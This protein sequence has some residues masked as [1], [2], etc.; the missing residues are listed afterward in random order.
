MPTGYSVHTEGPTQPSVVFVLIQSCFVWQRSGITGSVFFAAHLPA[1]IQ[2]S[3][4]VSLLQLLHQAWNTTLNPLI[5]RRCPLG[6]WSVL[7]VLAKHGPPPS[8]PPRSPSALE[9]PKT[10]T[11]PEAPQMPYKAGRKNFLH[12]LRLPFLSLQFSSIEYTPNKVQFY[13]LL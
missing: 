11:C 3:S 10:D 2:G 12:I 13:P 7:S 4:T 9:C 8:P 6:G 1:V 5:N